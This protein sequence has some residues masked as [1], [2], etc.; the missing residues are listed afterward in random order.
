MYNTVSF[1][2]VIGNNTEQ[3]LRSIDQGPVIA[4]ACAAQLTAKTLNV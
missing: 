3:D 2:L 1:F 4:S